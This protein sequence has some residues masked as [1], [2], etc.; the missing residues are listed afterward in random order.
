MTNEQEITNEMNFALASGQF[1][2]HLQPQYN[3]HTKLS[4][5]AEVLVRWRH[6]KKGLL[7]PGKF[8]PVFERNGFITKLDHYVWEEA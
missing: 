7:A 5:G 6:P 2:I 8:I 1:E 4:C 3:I